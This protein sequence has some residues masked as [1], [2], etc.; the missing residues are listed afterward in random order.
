MDRTHRSIDLNNYGAY[1]CHTVGPGTSNSSYWLSFEVKVTDLDGVPA[2]IQSVQVVYPDGET[3]R[4]LRYSREISSTEAIY[5]GDE[6]YND[7]SAIQEGVYTFMITDYDGLWRIGS[8]S[9]VVNDLPLPVN[10]TP[11]ADSVLTSTTPTVEWDDVP[12]AIRYRIRLYDGMDNPILWSDYLADSTYT[13]GQG[14]LEVDKTYSYRIYSYR[15]QA[16]DSDVNNCSINQVFYSDMPHFTIRADSDGDGVAD[17]ED[18]FPT[19]IDEWLDTGFR[20]HR[21]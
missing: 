5:E 19:D 8:D 1:V 21:R 16:P 17:V 14:V 10:V 4:D 18:A 9:L 15:E 2:N 6:M 7:S 20:R 12:G 3:T 13:F 11:A